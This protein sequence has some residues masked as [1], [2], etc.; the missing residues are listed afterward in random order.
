M[1][2]QVQVVLTGVR[3]PIN[4][5]PILFSEIKHLIINWQK[6]RRKFPELEC[7]NY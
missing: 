1:I 7:L 2:K 4:T 3:I 5:W 6:E